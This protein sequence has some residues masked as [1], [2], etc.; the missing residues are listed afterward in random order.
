M[1]SSPA[2]ISLYMN[3]S[4]GTVS[5]C[6]NSSPAIVSLCMNSSP[7]T[8]SLCMNSSPG[9]VSLC[10]NSSPGTVFIEL[11]KIGDRLYLNYLT[12]GYL[13]G[14]VLPLIAKPVLSI[15]CQLSRAPSQDPRL[16]DLILTMIVRYTK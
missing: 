3:S 12:Y 1:N 4:P 15:K 9:T 11:Q 2:T 5:L 16:I 14:Q 10:M 8:V 6:M 13:I 7:A